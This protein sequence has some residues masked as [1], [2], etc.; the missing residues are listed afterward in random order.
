MYYF[1]LN[2]IKFNFNLNKMRLEN[3]LKTL[4]YS[5]KTDI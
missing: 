3:E 4:K 5:N 1:F 2:N